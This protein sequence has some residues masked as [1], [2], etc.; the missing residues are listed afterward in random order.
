[1]YHMLIRGMQCQ[2]KVKPQLTQQCSD[3]VRV[4]KIMKINLEIIWLL[5]F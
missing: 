3:H 4:V 2:S 5:D 1:M